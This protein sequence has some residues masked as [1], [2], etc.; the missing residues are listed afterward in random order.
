MSQNHGQSENWLKSAQIK[1]KSPLPQPLP[2]PLPP[3]LPDEGMMVMIMMMMV[4]M[5]SWASLYER[6]LSNCFSYWNPM[7]PCSRLR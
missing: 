3:S 7:L 2:S 4:M 1:G 6:L 5:H